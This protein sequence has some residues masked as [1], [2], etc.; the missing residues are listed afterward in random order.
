M[1]QIVSGETLTNRGT[2]D[3]Q[4]GAVIL[5]DDSLL[6]TKLVQ[7]NLVP[8]GVPLNAGRVWDAPGSALPAA[9]AAD[10]L[11]LIPGTWGTDGLMIQSSDRKAGAGATQYARVLVPV[12]AEYMAGQTVQLRVVGGMVTTVSDGTATVDLECYLSTTGGDVGSDLCATAA[13]S[14]NALLSGTPTTVDFT[15]TSTSLVPGDLLDCRLAV[16]VTD[17]ATATAVIGAISRIALLCD[18]K[19]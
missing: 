12:P 15:I 2:I 8:Y 3:S 5:R 11:G 14:I 6:R 17:A 1:V 16:A 9:A 4:S 7:E 13:A 18:I 10:D 19:G